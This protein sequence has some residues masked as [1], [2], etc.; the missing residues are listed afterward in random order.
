MPEEQEQEQERLY[1]EFLDLD[2]DGNDEED[3]GFPVFPEFDLNDPK[4][5]AIRGKIQKLMKH[6]Q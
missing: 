4:E 6:P 2:D 3:E 1:P 5:I